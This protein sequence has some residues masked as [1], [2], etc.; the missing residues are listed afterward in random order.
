MLKFVFPNLMRMPRRQHDPEMRIFTLRYS[1]L[2]FCSPYRLLISEADAVIKL[3]SPGHS[4]TQFNL[5]EAE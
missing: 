1:L 2:P 3:H 5:T 4:Y